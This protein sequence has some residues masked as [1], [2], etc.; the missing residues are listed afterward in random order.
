MSHLRIFILYYCFEVIPKIHER[1]KFYLFQKFLLKI[2]D[3]LVFYLLGVGHMR[4]PPTES[5][6]IFS[7]SIAKLRGYFVHKHFKT[8]A[9]SVFIIVLALQWMQITNERSK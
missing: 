9:F 8:F 4:F 2:L 6:Y 1:S 5:W 3:V 7:Q